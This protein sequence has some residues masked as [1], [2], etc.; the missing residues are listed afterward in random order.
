MK[1]RIH[2]YLPFS[3]ANGPGCRAVFWVQGC[4]LSCPGCFNPE[5]HAFAQGQWIEIDD[6]LHRVQTIA[7]RIEG[8][9]I[10]GGEPLVQVA[11]V[12]EYVRRVKQST[13]LSVILLT[14]FGWEEVQPIV[15]RQPATVNR[16]TSEHGQN[17][18]SDPTLP[19]AD[20]L[21][22]VDVLIAGR[23]DQSQ[24]L[25]QGLRGSANKTLHFLT[26]RYGASDLARVP[27]GEV[28]VHP[29]GEIVVSGVEPPSPQ[30]QYRET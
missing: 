25:A 12:Q 26:D 8:I 10:S 4:P 6:L 9:T 2:S 16:A 1:L 7:D 19:G 27:G 5:T 15:G 24:R 22:Y 13:P 30:L 18:A 3:R 28:I 14:G 23:Y 21:S 17:Q 20:L 11:A 29:D